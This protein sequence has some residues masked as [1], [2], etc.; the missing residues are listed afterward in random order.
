MDIR[1]QDLFYTTSHLVAFDAYRTSKSAR[2]DAIINYSGTTTNIGNAM[3]VETGKFTAPIDGHYF[4]SFQG[5]CGGDM[6]ISSVYMFVNGARVS[7]GLQ[8]TVSATLNQGRR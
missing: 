3:D 6:D 5:L 8:E 1:I 4:F 7:T 2:Q